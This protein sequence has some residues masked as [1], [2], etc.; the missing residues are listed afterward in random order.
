MSKSGQVANPTKA[1]QFHI[2]AHGPMP[3]RP[4][5]PSKEQLKSLVVTLKAGK[6]GQLNKSGLADLLKSKFKASHSRSS[7]SSR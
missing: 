1:L 7:A 3:R 2:Q 5:R 4:R 6:P